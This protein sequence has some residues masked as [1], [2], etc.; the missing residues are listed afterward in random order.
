MVFFSPHWMSE[1]LTKRL[2][3]KS[4]GAVLYAPGKRLLLIEYP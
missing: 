2:G 3:T 4:I 1:F